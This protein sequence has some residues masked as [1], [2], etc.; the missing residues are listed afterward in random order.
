MTRAS[1]VIGLR[2]GE[3]MNVH[4]LL[5]AMMLPS[6]NDAAHA[7]AVRVGHTEARFVRQMNAEVTAP[8][9]E[10]DPLLHA[11][12]PR[13]SPQLLERPRPGAARDARHAR[14]ELLAT[15]SASR[16]P[17][18]SP[19]RIRGSWSTATTWWLRYPFVDGVKTG[20][21]LDAGYV[22]VGAAHAHGASVISVVL[23]DPSEATRD[24]D[25]LA[26]LRYGL[27]QYK[28]VRPRG[29]RARRGAR[30]GALARRAGER[31]RPAAASSSRCGAAHRST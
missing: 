2:Q 4:D 5:R 24:A 20:H 9:P 15:S 21:T 12:R 8:R 28:R 10:P 17:S 19:G 18:C 25:S 14:Q 22:L 23:G 6:A 29:R 3:R 7:L 11:D 30:E 16:A 13:R 1:R 26:L 27:A 31:S